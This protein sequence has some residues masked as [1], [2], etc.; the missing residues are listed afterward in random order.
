MIGID[1]LS[2]IETE[3]VGIVSDETKDVHFTW[4]AIIA[5]V[6]DALQKAFADIGLIGNLVER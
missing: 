6:L 5:I 3:E 4:K 2:G 1:H